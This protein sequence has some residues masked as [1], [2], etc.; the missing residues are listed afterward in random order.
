MMP[1]LVSAVLLLPALLAAGWEAVP[2]GGEAMLPADPIASMRLSAAAETASGEI[3]SVE[4]MPF[5]RAYRVRITRAPEQVWGVQ[6]LARTTGEIARGDVLL[7]S[8]FARGSTTANESGEAHGAAYVQRNGGGYEKLVSSAFSAGSQWKQLLV[9]FEAPFPLASGQHEITLHL[10]YL[11][12]TVEVGGLSLV[13]YRASKTVAGLPKTRIGYEGAAPDSPWRAEAAARIEEIRKA[14][15]RVSVEHAGG[16]PAAGA[17][18]RVLQKRHRFPFGSAVAADAL[19]APGENGERYR[20]TIRTWFNKAVLENDLKWPQW[21]ANPQKALDALEWM[22]EHEIPVRGHTLVWPGWKRMPADVQ[23]LAGDPEALRSRVLRHIQEE[24]SAVRGKVTDWDVINE[25]Y[26]N[27]DLQ[28]ILGEQEMARWFETAREHDPWATLYIND[29]GILSNGGNDR[30]HQDH[31]FE[32]IGKLIEWGAP[33][34]AIGMQGHFGAALTPPTRLWQILDRFAAHG[35]PV[36][37]T[38]F[39][40]DID[41]EQAQADYTRDFLTAVFAHPSVNGFMMWGFWEGRHWRPRAAMFRRD[42]SLKPNGRV[43]RDL[44][45]REWWTDVRGRTGAGGDFQTRGFLG[46]YEVEAVLG[47]RK[48]SARVRLEAGGSAVT[49]KLP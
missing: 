24:V 47:D 17:E 4:G 11:P 13:N 12:Q 20:E 36:H 15:L 3:V 18:I 8:L 33:L 10:G 1:R 5:E 7:L 28:K 32:T 49:L 31:Y 40:I 43:F 38:E 45:F 44:V 22:R 2:E 48:A 27:T 25:P 46:D 16:G 35:L 6:I 21:E 37:I 34:Q 29:Y 19:L 39:D 30:R 9:P 26:S 14:D 42:W 41:D 23:Q